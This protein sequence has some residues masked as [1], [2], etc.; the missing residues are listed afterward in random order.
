[1]QSAALLVVRPSNDHPEYRYRYVDLRVEDHPDPINELIRLYRIYERTG[2]LEA[3]VRYIQI[4]E[5]SGNEALL[6]HER[7][8]VGDLIRR[9]LNDENA[10]ADELNSIGWICATHDMHLQEALQAAERAVALKPDEAYIVD[11]LAEVYFRLG[12]IEQ[13]ITTGE[14]AARLDPESSYYQE[15]LARFRASGKED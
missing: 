4:F 13:A 15:Q 1:M 12:E 2:L 7:S 10:T 14:K 5:A 9:S 3:H 11:T 8:A 6:R